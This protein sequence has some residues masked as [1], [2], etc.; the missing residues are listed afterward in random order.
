MRKT[1]MIFGVFA[2]SLASSSCLR[3]QKTQ[4]RAFTPPP[5]RT[6]PTVPDAV[7]SLPDAPQIAADSAAMV[8][9]QL[10]EMT[11]E[12]MPE[13]PDSPKRV[14]RRPAVTQPKPAV[15]GTA[16][17][18]SPAP[19]RL[20]QLY[21]PEE[22][23]DNT[24]TLDESLE[25]VNR[26]VANIEGKNLTVEQRETLERIRTFKKQAEQ[27]REQDLMTAVILARRADLLAKD[28]LEHLP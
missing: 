2:L 10:P 22:Q 4:A 18:E 23:R 1:R 3:Q 24:R 27:V 25:R 8:P 6:W 7:P 16:T 20:A 17:P 19:P 9:P 21:S 13:V 11:P 15:P 12:T 14:A 5:P 26:N 28:L